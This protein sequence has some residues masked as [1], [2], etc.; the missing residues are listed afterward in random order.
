V[1]GLQAHR[2]LH[3]TE[4]RRDN[5]GCP[6]ASGSPRDGEPELFIRIRLGS[7][8]P[9][10]TDEKGVPRATQYAVD[11]EA[12]ALVQ[13]TID[14]SVCRPVGLLGQQV[15]HGLKEQGYLAIGG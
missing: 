14:M 9:T 7:A 2:R 13:T 4:E 3:G 11:V 10:T 8:L 12:V 15:P 6:G 5:R 1:L